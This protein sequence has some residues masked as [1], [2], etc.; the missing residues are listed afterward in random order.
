MFTDIVGSTGLRDTLV[1]KHGGNNGDQQYREQLLEPHHARIRAFL[2]KHNGFEVKT[3]GD[4]FMASFASAEDAIRCAVDIQRS[5]RDQPIVGDETPESLAIR[6]GIHS[7]W[8]GTQ[9]NRGIV[10]SDLPAG[11]RGENL[12]KA[13]ACYEAALRVYTERDFPADWATTQNNLGAAYWNLPA[14]DR[15]ENLKKA[16]AC[17]EAALRVRTE[18]D[19]P[20]GWADTQYNLGN[21]YEERATGA[22]GSDRR[23]AILCFE[24][25]ARGY[26]AV[27]IADE[28]EEALQ[29]ARALAADAS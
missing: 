28:A 6:I 3:I 23:L 11:D 10:Y 26:A 17:Y 29:R 8:A 14:D 20:R 22:E 4:S 13:I 16:I 15:R 7:A 19:F 27:G 5:L 12:K 25:A 24:S 18:S 1:A 21:L 2:E 9:N